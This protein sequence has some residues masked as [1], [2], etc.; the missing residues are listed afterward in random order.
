M[1]Q[2]S[3]GDE[4][5]SCESIIKGLEKSRVLTMTRSGDV[6]ELREGCDGYYMATLSK[7]Q[8]LILIEELRVFVE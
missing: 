4:L 7:E 5:I 2:I 1:H 8:M 3:D 6:F